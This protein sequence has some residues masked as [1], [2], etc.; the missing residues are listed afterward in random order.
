MKKRIQRY[1]FHIGHW[2]LRVSRWTLYASAATLVLLAVVFAIAHHLLPMLEERKPELEQFLSLHSGHRVQIESLHA[3]WDG[4]HP[5]AQVKGMQVFATDGHR[6]AI[7]LS[8]VRISLALLPLLWGKLEINSLVV[9]NPSL[10]LERL[11]DGRFRISGFNPLQAEQQTDDE[12]FIGWLFRQGRLEIENG[13]FQWIDLRSADSPR[14]HLAHVNL[15]LENRGSSHRLEFSAEFPPRMCRE[16]SLTLDI[17][18]N[19]FVSPAWDGEIYLRAAEVDVDALPLVVRE[20]LPESFRGKFSAQLWSDWNEGRP[21]AVRGNLRASSLRLPVPGQ[22]ASLDIR[23]AGGDLSWKT[24]RAGWRLDIAN[25]VIGLVGPVWSAEHIRIVYQPDDSEIQIRRLN[26]GDITGFAMRQK[27][28]L[29]EAV[30]NAPAKSGD[31]LDY[32]LAARPEGGADNFNLRIYKD[33]DA[34]DFLLETD[35]SAAAVLPYEKYPGVQGLSGHLSVSRHTGNLRLDSSDISVSLP[36]IF[37]APLKAKRASAELSWKKYDDYWLIT[38]DKL[39]VTGDAQ[40]TGKLSVRVPLDNSVSPQLKLRVDFH[41]GNGAYAAR[42][43]PAEILSPSTLAWMERSFLG[44]EITQGYMIYDGP[45]RDF[46]FRQHTGKFEL[47]GH[48]RRGIYRFLPGWEPVKQAEVD[49]AVN[50][51]EVLVTGSG[52]IGT[53]DAGQVVVRSQDTSDGHSVVHVSSKVTGPV[54]ETLKVLREV[55]PEPGTASWLAYIPAGLQGAGEGVLNL[56]L[57]ILPGQVPP[58]TGTGEYRFL[59]STLRFPGNG[60][61]AEGIE[62]SVRFSESGIR[63]GI[64][65]SRFLG[66]ETVLAASQEQGRLKVHGEGVIPAP[67]LAPMVGPRIAPRIAGSLSWNGSWQRNK[68]AGEIYAEVDLRNLRTSLPA[69]LDQPKGLA[70]EKLI[71]RTESSTSDKIALGINVGTRMS[72]KLLFGRE[73]GGW[74]LT[75]GRIGFG[76]PLATLPKERGLQVSARLDEVDVDRWWPL[77]G[78]GSG[79]VPSWLNHVSAEVRSLNMLDRRFGN[80]SL[81]FTRE[82]D[83]WYGNVGGD[84]IAGYVK[85]SG[86]GPAARYEL[87]LTRLVLPDRQHDL[88]DDQTDPRRLPTVELRSKSFQVHD[89]QLGEL[90]FAASPGE[91][92]WTITRLNFT[93]PEMKLGINGNW[94]YSEGRHASSFVIELNTTDIGKTMEAFGMPDQMAGGQATVKSHLSW[95]GSPANVQLATLN[96]GI[97]VSAKK[98]RFL[99]VKQ[100]AGRLFGLLDL[101]AI[102][103]YLTLDFSP[104]FG[105]GFIYDQIHGEVTIEKGN[106]NTRSFSIHGPAMEIDMT[107]RIGLVAED[108]DLVLELQPKVSDAVTIASWGVWGPQVAAVMLAVQTIFKKQIAAGTRITYVVKGPWNNPVINKQVKEK[109]PEFPV[110]SPKSDDEAGVR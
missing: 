28:E 56:D 11:A 13:E 16:C 106:A 83:T 42:Y 1:A 3:Y 77:L 30:K 69:P 53:L 37:R 81:D 76:E 10:V 50:G 17:T 48:V 99:H 102:S 58:T 24:S 105:K 84:C 31:W 5:G 67:S 55:K 43:Y 80:F 109:K 86:N 46:P 40:G 18:G 29:V 36:R 21:V 70:D 54:N 82:G 108:F 96:G 52:K 73:T 72:G 26:I 32:W 19:P 65:R 34:T 91:S 27:S 62:G 49:V 79:G 104:V 23:E 15:S 7:R 90:D 39:R 66:G 74:R 12:K 100:G 95:P 47:R 64:L 14:V 57:N 35:I 25:P 20:K 2:T 8:E 87:D 110:A 92:G 22:S 44:G 33:G 68:D 61:A 63:D 89:K 6:S 103:R 45:I 98:G 78:D 94:Q 38:G 60:V 107:G 9:V 101:S 51:P 97:E 59:K 85:F 88:R 75:R 93:R 41:D 4:L 71:I